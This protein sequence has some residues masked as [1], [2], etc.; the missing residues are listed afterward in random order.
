MKYGL[1]V[2]MVSLQFRLAKLD[3]SRSR[4]FSSHGARLEK[5]F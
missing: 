4:I 3:L 2:L 5:K 1:G